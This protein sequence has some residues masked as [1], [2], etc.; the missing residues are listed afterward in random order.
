MFR[1]STS[2]IPRRDRDPGLWVLGWLCPGWGCGLQDVES[3]V[4]W[5]TGAACELCAESGQDKAAACERARRAKAVEREA[6][7]QPC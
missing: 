2:I 6:C 4:T 1:F 3:G 7:G 5:R